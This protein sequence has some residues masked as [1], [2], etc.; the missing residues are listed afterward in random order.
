VQD[1]ATL[2]ILVAVPDK[3]DQLRLDFNQGKQMQKVVKAGFSKVDITP[4]EP[5][6]L[7]GYGFYL[8]RVFRRVHDPLYARA[9]AIEMG[10]ARVL[11]ISCDLVGLSSKAAEAI[12]AQLKKDTGLAQEAILLHCTHTHTGPATDELRACG[13]AD[14]KYTQGLT[15]KVVAAGRQAWR[16]LAA[17]EK[18]TYADTQVPELAFNRTYKK[19]GPLDETLRTVF[20]ARKRKAAIALCNYSCHPVSVGC[21]DQVSAD[22]PGQVV[23][24]LEAKG[25]QGI[26]LTGF[27]GDIDPTGKKR[28]FAN[29]ARIGR[30]LAKAA[31]QTAAQVRA[32]EMTEL[33]GM[34]RKVRIPLQVPSDA[35][36]LARLRNA[37]DAL[38]AAPEKREHLHTIAWNAEALAAKQ[39]KSFKPYTDTYLQ[40]I[41]LGDIVLIAFPGE[42]FTSLG[43][44]LRAQFPKQDL[45]CVN[46]ANGL[47]GYIPTAD[48]FDCKSYA[49]FMAAGIYG[50]FQMARGFGEK[51]GVEAGKLIQSLTAKTRRTQSRRKGT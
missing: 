34:V 3:T 42:T 18:V 37:K 27:C 5:V 40:A 50:N 31:L 19:D 29:A 46:T 12:K 15:A 4:T 2:T 28:G 25:Y 8:Q 9:L 41:K 35:E 6:E 1:K 45:I 48:E 26:F 24:Q 7:C 14:E 16:D 32:V 30:A 17:V 33:R 23:K 51:L 20:F 11:I 22:Y 47:I 38:E 21:R 39:L 43:L 10:A 44:Q 13:Q 49:A 36:L